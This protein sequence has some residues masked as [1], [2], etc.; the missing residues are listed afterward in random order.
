MFSKT[1][2]NTAETLLD[3]T[4]SDNTPVLSTPF[5]ILG[6]SKLALQIAWYGTLVGTWSKIQLSNS[7]VIAPGSAL[8]T[9]IT[10]AADPLVDFMTAG[11]G[12]VN[13]TPN[14]ALIEWETAAGAIQLEFTR[15]AGSGRLWIVGTAK[16]G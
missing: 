13:G 9:P 6:Y 15:S 14:S 2:Y 16:R 5:E 1:D 10:D 12:V 3:Q 8:F 7:Y 4:I 11:D